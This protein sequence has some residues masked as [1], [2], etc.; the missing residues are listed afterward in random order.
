MTEGD[1]LIVGGGIA[2]LALA[3]FLDDD[4]GVEPTVVERAPDLHRTGWAVGLWG[5]GTA[6]LEQLG[7]LD[8]AVSRGSTPDSFEVRTSDEVLASVSIPGEKSFL[9]VHRSDLTAALAEGVPDERLRMGTTVRGVEEE[10]DGVSVVYDDG[11]TETYD[12]VVG[13]DGIRSR[14]RNEVFDDPEAEERGTVAWSF[15][16]PS[17]VDADL[18]DSLVSL[19]EPGTGVIMDR[20]GDRALVNVATREPAGRTPE[21]PALRLLSRVADDVGWR[22][23]DYVDALDASDVFFA[24]DYEVDM[25]SWHR[26]RTLLVGDAAHAVHPI[27]A[28]GASL[29]L[30]DAYVLADELRSA[31]SVPDSFSSFEDRRRD[32]VES[33]RRTAHVEERVIFTRSPLVTLPRNALVRWTSVLER[34]F[35]SQIDE[36]RNFSLDDI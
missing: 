16:V 8:E 28:M 11:T 19:L 2:G 22:L 32:R 9:S 12:A 31:E 14:V 36:F 10:G 24:R 1:V 35:E 30:E 34:A 29:A 3:G 26:H 7:V 27:V 6:V 18:P 20:V 5:N 21:P 4:T 33:V 13:A 23:P 25:D 17:D 15:W